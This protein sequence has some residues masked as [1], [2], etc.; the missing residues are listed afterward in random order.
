MDIE[1]ARK[2][3]NRVAFLSVAAAILL[4]SFKLVVGLLTGSLG[5]LSEALHSA[6][7]FVAAGI[8]WFA[9]RLSDKPADSDHHYGH[10][11]I[12]NLSALLETV[13]LLITCV[14]IIY[15]AVSRL[16]SGETHIEVNLWSYIVVITSIVI[17]ISRSRALMRVA[18]KYNSQA[19]EA[20]ALHFST[21]I[22][23]SLVVLL[24]LI[25]ANFGIFIADSIAA[26]IVASIVIYISYK[27]GKRS[28]NVL[29]DRVPEETYQKIV[30]I[31]DGLTEIECYHDLKVRA[32]GAEFFVELNIHVSPELSIP[33]SHDIAH[34][35][36]DKIKAEILR[37][38]VHVHIE[39]EEHIEFSE[40]NEDVEL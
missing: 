3:K 32:A 34:F 9:V 8:T 38:H 35:I 18:K 19:L 39:P 4:T 28:I 14:W 33:Q 24:G 36:E 20:D 2:E 27:L 31:L 26:L 10:G 30:F 5:I 7:D 37:C 21:D 13:L 16:S 12:E 1:S 22:W 6:L 15:E 11:K 25:C 29:L 23:S 40:K 17:D